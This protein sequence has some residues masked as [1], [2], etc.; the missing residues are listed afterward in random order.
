MVQLV[1]RDNEQKRICFA[2]GLCPAPQKLDRPIAVPVSP[3]E[4]C[5]D[6]VRAQVVGLVSP[7][8]QA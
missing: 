7:R 1:I 6:V 5:T 2:T 8:R 3:G 4:L